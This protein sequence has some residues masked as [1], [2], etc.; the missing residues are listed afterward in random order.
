M[1]KELL[2]K[3]IELLCK[4]RNI[5]LT[6]AFLQSGVGKNFKSNMNTSNPSMGKLTMLAN[7]FNVT[8]NYLLGETDNPDTLDKQLEGVEFA[9]FGEVKELT[10]EQKKDVLKFVQFLKTQNGD[11]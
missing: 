1:N 9:L 3:R 11:N 8:V 2:I 6:T 4:E 7:Y 5:S 10:E